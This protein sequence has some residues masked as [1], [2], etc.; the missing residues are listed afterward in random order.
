MRDLTMP[1]AVRVTESTLAFINGLTIYGLVFRQTLVTE[2]ALL[3]VLEI[4]GMPNSLCHGVE[5]T[6]SS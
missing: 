3:S 6:E 5:N 2:S 4:V 1:G